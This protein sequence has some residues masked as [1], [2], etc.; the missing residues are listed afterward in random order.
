M[1]MHMHS[2]MQVAEELYITQD[3]E[4]LCVLASYIIH[5]GS[6]TPANIYTRVLMHDSDMYGVRERRLAWTFLTL[7]RPKVT[8]V[9]QLASSINY[10]H[11]RKLV[12]PRKLRAGC[13]DDFHIIS[14]ENQEAS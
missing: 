12:P 1:G 13:I 3:S 8:H 7:A 4:A 2:Q 14:M 5:E 11:E 6:Y 10:L 9:V